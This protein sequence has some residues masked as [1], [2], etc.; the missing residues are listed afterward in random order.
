MK[1]SAAGTSMDMTVS[2]TR[3]GVPVDTTPPP[4]DQVLDAGKLLGA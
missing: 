4:A 2:F 1:F 3:F